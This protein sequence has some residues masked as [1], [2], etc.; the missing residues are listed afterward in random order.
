VVGLDRRIGDLGGAD[1]LR[2]VVD[3]CFHVGLRAPVKTGKVL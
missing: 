2:A 3:G 1:L